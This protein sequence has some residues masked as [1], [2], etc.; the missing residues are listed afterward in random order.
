MLPSVQSFVLQ[1]KTLFPHL[2]FVSTFIPFHCVTIITAGNDK[3]FFHCVCFSVKI[4]LACWGISSLFLSAWGCFW[5]FQL[6]A[7]IQSWNPPDTW[8][9]QSHVERKFVHSNFCSWLGLTKGL[10]IGKRSPTNLYY[11]DNRPS[12]RSHFSISFFVSYFDFFSWAL[13]TVVSTHK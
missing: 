11:I 1:S 13:T 9:F 2:N 7:V 5:T 8:I 6:S 10:L 4:Y 12:H 3:L